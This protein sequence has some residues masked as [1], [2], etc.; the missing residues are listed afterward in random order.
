[1]DLAG[2]VI[3]AVLVEGRSVKD[4]CEAHDISRSW[5]YEL[6]ARYRELGDDGLRPL[7]KRPGSSPTQVGSA[8]EDEIVA[9]RKELT[10]LGVDAGAHTIHYHLTRRHR[11]GHRAVPSVATIW[12]V[13]SRR[14]F[15]TPQPHKRPRSSWRRFQ[16]ELPNECWQADTTDGSAVD[17][18]YDGQIATP[19]AGPT[20]ITDN[21]LL[22]AV[23]MTDTVPPL[24]GEKGAGSEPAT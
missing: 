13:L 20:L 1:M 22:V 5:L 9:L 23:S 10:D 14:G 18:R 6:I 24:G 19:P 21:T 7:S 12:R 16:A 8:I 11:R 4:V 3:N 15:V 17:P 2:Y